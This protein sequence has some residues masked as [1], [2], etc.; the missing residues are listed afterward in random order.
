MNGGNQLLTYKSGTTLEQ[1]DVQTKNAV[2]L[3]S[4][5]DTYAFMEQDTSEIY[6]IPADQIE[7][8]IP[9]L[10]ENLDCF[11]M[12]F[13]GNVIG[14][15]LPNVIEYKIEQTVPGVKG[16]RATAGKKPA[17]LDNGLEVMVALHLEAG[18]TVRI[19]T[20]TGDIA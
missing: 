11:I 18:A 13:E 10:K 4:G 1:V 2:Y 14:V 19:N 5:G 17:T 16:D 15:I 8:V 6:D 20:V 9:Y 7:D 12:I 3:Y